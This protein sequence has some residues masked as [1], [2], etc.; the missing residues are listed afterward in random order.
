LYGSS[1]NSEKWARFLVYS[2]SDNISVNKFRLAIGDNV[3]KRT[4][5]QINIYSVNNYDTTSTYNNNIKT[6]NNNGLTLVGNLNWTGNVSSQR[7]EVS[8]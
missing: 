3:D 5:K 6:R 1:A 8:Y 7:Y 4:P 2:W